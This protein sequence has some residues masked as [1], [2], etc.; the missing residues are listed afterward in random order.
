M[1]ID[2]SDMNKMLKTAVKPI[3]DCSKYV[4]NAI[5]C[6]CDSSCCKCTCETKEIPVSDSESDD[7][8][9]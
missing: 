8:K 4:C 3:D 7:E 6:E 9:T 2:S 1:G 5:K